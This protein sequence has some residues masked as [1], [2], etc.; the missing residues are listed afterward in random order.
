[1]EHLEVGSIRVRTVDTEPGS[2][3][4]YLIDA[5]EHPTDLDAIADGCRSVVVSLPV[6]DW[7]V[8]LTPWPAPGLRRG[9][10]D[11]GGRANETLGEVAAAIGDIERGHGLSP[12]RRAICGYSLA[13]LFSIYAFARSGLFAA[14]ASVSGS[15]WYEGWADWLRALP[16]DGTG[17][18]AYLSVGS[19]EKHAPNPRMR[20]VEADMLACADILRQ[21]GCEVVTEV[22]PGSHFQHQTER[23]AAA[24]TALDSFLGRT[25]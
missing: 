14:F 15:V 10:A 22:G 5:P 24:I 25:E 18:F 16:L 1:M 3:V 13:G 4:I 2:P 19:R 21:D 17:R 20:S 6:R 23:L 11:F 8:S 12:T 7:A 9:S